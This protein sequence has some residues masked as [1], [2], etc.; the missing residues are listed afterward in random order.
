MNARWLFAPG[1]AASAGWWRLFLAGGVL[2]A[3]APALRLAPGFPGG[4]RVWTTG[5]GIAAAVL[6]AVALA[7]GARRRMPRRG[8]FALHQWVQAHVYGGTLYLVLLA[9]HGGARMPDGVLSWGLWVSS[10]WVVATG[11][12]GVFIQKWIPP[13]LTS[14]LATEVHHDRIPELVA[15]VREEVEFLV[16]ASGD[17]VRR[18]HETNLKPALA[19]PRAT[20]TYLFD[21]TGGI[22]SRM[23]RFDYQKRLLEGDDVRRL[24]RLRI[25]MRTKLEMDAHYTLQKALRWWLYLHVPAAGLLTALVAVHVFAVVYY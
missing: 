10:L 17:S 11:L 13:A 19:G 15:A 18:F 1:P 14:G 4:D 12:L 2:C 7:Y 22:Q 24:E 6:L 9:L 16:A 23:R 20:L 21:V 8:P 25:L 3:A 5:Y